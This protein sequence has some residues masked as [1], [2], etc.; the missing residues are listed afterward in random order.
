[1]VGGLG[2]VLRCDV[3]ET[4]CD[5]LANN[6]SNLV[7]TLKYSRFLKV[8]KVSRTDTSRVFLGV[9]DGALIFTILLLL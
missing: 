4:K 9:Y 1:M 2:E 8:F 5:L 7:W 6:F 3:V